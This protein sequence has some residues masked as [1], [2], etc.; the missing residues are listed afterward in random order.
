MNKLTLYG[1]IVSLSLIIHGCAQ[2][3]KQPSKDV[4]LADNQQLTQ[5]QLSGK[6]GLRNGN[7]GHSAYLNWK[8]CGD[9]YDIRLTGPLGQGAARLTGDNTLAELNTSDQQ[10]YQSSNAENLLAVHF[11]W[12]LPVNQLLYWI[13]GIPSPEYAVEFVKQTQ[14]QTHSFHQLDWQL[15]YPKLMMV[16]GLQLP[17]KAIVEQPP[18]KVTLL[19]KEWQLQ[20]DCD[21]E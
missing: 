10:T 3:P 19:I 6:I 18:L 15:T 17:A 20:P 13:R 21:A 2:I 8:Q 14:P 16:N 1:L 11:G 4:S 9:R 12:Q 5:W 7:K